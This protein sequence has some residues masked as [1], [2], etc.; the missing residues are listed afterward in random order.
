MS[1]FSGCSFILC[2]NREELMP[3]KTLILASTETEAS[4]SEQ[5]MGS[6]P[7]S[8]L[9][10]LCSEKRLLFTSSSTLPPRPEVAEQ[11]LLRFETLL[12]CSD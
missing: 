4:L 5:H 3:N 9:A 12:I 7:S 2:I 11:P 1:S 6:L 8:T 10:K